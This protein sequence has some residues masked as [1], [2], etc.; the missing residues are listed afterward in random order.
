[1]SRLR[2]W[3]QGYAVVL[4]PL[5]LSACGAGPVLPTSYPTH[6]PYPTATPY[7]TP[8]TIST[9][10][11]FA[12]AVYNRI[13][14]DERM[15]AAGKEAVISLFAHRPTFAF[16]ENKGLVVQF[17]IPRYPTPLEAKLAAYQL[18]E[19]AVS[20]AAEQGITLDGAEV[21]Y[22]HEG[23]PWAALASKP[24]WGDDQL[25]LVPLSK[26]MIKQLL[27]AGLITPTPQPSY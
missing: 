25:F 5:C 18:I 23:E 27:D 6:T 19:A 20:T 4:L 3:G 16:A 26:Q 17:N 9:D 10:E 21:V 2:R 1:M 12:Q 13:D 14:A 15:P 7:P 8:T 11:V 24:P 22:S